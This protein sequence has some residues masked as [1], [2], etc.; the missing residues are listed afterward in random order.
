MS[1]VIA[2]TV[3]IGMGPA[4][5]LPLFLWWLGKVAF[6]CCHGFVILSLYRIYATISLIKIELG[7]CCLRFTGDLKKKVYFQVPT[8][9]PGQYGFL[10]ISIRFDIYIVTYSR[11]T[12]EISFLFSRY[13]LAV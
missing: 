12:Y 2:G 6:G 5:Q 1:L 8:V 9:F 3:I 7:T 4:F 13:S 10:D 11:M